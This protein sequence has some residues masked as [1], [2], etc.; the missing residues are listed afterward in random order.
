[1]IGYDYIK[2]KKQEDQDESDALYGFAAG[3]IGGIAASFMMNQFDDI[4]DRIAEN[5]EKRLSREEPRLERR[6]ENKSET[7]APVRAADAVA[8]NSMG[9]SLSQRE[10][11]ATSTAAQYA[12]AS[13]MGGVY[14][15]VLESAPHI[16][17][18]VGAPAAIV[19]FLFSHVAAPGIGSRRRMIR[20]SSGMG[21]AFAARVVY[22]ATSATVR[23]VLRRY[24]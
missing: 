11:Q 2:R 6:E 24:I 8:R 23:R 17:K 3:V 18:R 1:M 5:R 14:G 12:S 19:L 21:D 9:R 15:A 22:G 13:I 4:T 7:P 20:R 10:K 16:A